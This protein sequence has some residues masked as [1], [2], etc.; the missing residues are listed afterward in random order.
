MHGNVMEWCQ[1]WHG[2]NYYDLLQNDVTVDPFGAESGFTKVIRGG[3]WSNHASIQGSACRYKLIPIGVTNGVGIRVALS[4]PKMG[5]A[6]S[7]EL[8]KETLRSIEVEIA[9]QIVP[10]AEVSTVGLNGES[11]APN[12]GPGWHGWPDDAP[13]PAIA[14]FDAEKAKQHQEAWAKYLNVPVQFTNSIGMKLMLIPPGE[15]TM[16]STL[17]QID[18]A[19]KFV[20]GHKHW[21]ECIKSEAPPSQCDFD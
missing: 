3:N 9:P 21:Q 15:F 5:D 1:D 2:Q 6:V 19:V 12:S 18:E 13:P 11:E 17:D 4:I 8:T 16:G 10:I 14:P 20:G 7:R